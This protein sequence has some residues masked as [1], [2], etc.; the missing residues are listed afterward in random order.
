MIDYIRCRVP[1]SLPHPINGG[2]T[3]ILDAEGQVKRSTPHRLGIPGSFEAKLHVRAP[4][5]SFLEIEGN[6]AKFLQGHNLFGT[7]DMHALIWATVVAVLAGLPDPMTPD[8]AGITPASLVGTVITRV[9]CTF[10]LQLDSK[11][12]VLAWIRSAYASGRSNRRGRGVMRGDTLVFGDAQG[13]N[14]ARWQIVIYAKGQEVEVHPLPMPLAHDPAV[15]DWTD[16][17]LRVEVRLGR[18]ELEKLGKRQLCGWLPRG[19]VDVPGEPSEVSRIWRSK[20]DQLSFNNCADLHVET[21]K[22]P[23][24]LRT[25]YIS[26]KAGADLR[27][28]L[29]KP[30]FYR[31][32]ADLLALTGQDIAIPVPVTPTA[33]IIPIKRVLE[34]RPVGRPDWADRIELELAQYGCKA[35]PGAA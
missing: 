31:H 35:L 5:V 30:T 26:W 20:V 6:P 32:R 27:A 29:S 9:D 28:L 1:C 24:K 16:R 13:A 12:D 17:C 22:L 21:E 33:K 25:T 14:F 18:L 19:G 3:V 7:D 11:A 2:H 8:E 4:S 15:R 10:M 34:A 23:R